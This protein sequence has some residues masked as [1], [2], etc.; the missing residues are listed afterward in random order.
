MCMDPIVS[1]SLDTPGSLFAGQLDFLFPGCLFLPFPFA[2]IGVF[3]FFLI[4]CRP[5]KYILC[6]SSVH[7]PPMVSFTKLKL[8]F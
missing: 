7:S 6:L 8:I 1:V 5:L 4:I 2:P 3:I